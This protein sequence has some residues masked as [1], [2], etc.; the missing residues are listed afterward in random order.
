MTSF[1]W[2]YQITSPKYVIKMTSQFF[3]FSSPSLSKILVA[4][5]GEGSIFRDFVRTSFMEGPLL[6]TCVRYSLLKEMQHTGIS[7]LISQVR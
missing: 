5:L 6:I 4:P 1:W 3:S 7:L 2:R